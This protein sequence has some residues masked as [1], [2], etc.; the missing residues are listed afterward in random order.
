M[1][2]WTIMVYM[3]GDNNL[4]EDMI[5]G[6][7]GMQAGF[8]NRGKD[9]A[10]LAFYDG[11]ELNN[12]TF[13]LDFTN[14]KQ[15][16]DPSTDYKESSEYDEI[17]GEQATSYYSISNFVQWC[18]KNYEAKNYALIFSGHSD[19]FMQTALFID[20]TS[21]SYVTVRGLHYILSNICRNILGRE[22]IDIVG[23]DSCST[24]TLEVANELKK[25][26][27]ILI[28]SE[29]YVPRIGWNYQGII[30]KLDNFEGALTKEKFAEVVID[31]FQED[32]CE[33]AKYSGRAVN[34][35]CTDLGQIDLLTGAVNNLAGSLEA[36]LKNPN[37]G[38]RTEQI[39][40]SSHF[41]CQTF[42]LDQAID[43]QDFCEILQ[44]ECFDG[45]DGD[46]KSIFDF[47]NDV[48][49]AVKSCVGQNNR[50]IG[51]EFQYSRGISLFFPWSYVSYKMTRNRYL[52]L[53]FPLGRE[54]PFYAN[55]RGMPGRT[56]V[57]T[58]RRGVTTN[59]SE[60]KGAWVSFLDNYLFGTMRKPS[61]DAQK[62]NNA[63]G[64]LETLNPFLVEPT[65][66]PFDNVRANN[67]TGQPRGSSIYDRP[68]GI[69]LGFIE[70]FRRFKNYPWLLRFKNK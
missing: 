31:S 56:E 20:Q 6:L 9:I 23:F 46:F 66:S 36:A 59:Q 2:E 47:C 34:I 42:Q 62:S 12:E 39:I 45:K 58:E 18:H 33:Y 41:K 69:S 60:E 67:Q 7:I 52:K 24:N 32:N 4:S 27:G 43:I 26:A 51:P 10:L 64:D 49:E 25:V 68:R 37:I 19:V 5:T 14:K 50:H 65:A 38:K 54:Y 16:R 57:T 30:K 8:E 48:I 70:N 40:L 21:N 55:R 35:S 61:D 11:N 44:Q 3:A 63:E 29:G 22:K 13:Y 28:G 53:E 15:F 1:K 17:L